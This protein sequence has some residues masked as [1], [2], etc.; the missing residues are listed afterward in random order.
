MDCWFWLSASVPHRLESP[1]LL[2][3]LS[4]AAIM[5]VHRTQSSITASLASLH[6]RCQLLRLFSGQQG[7]ATKHPTN[8]Q[9][10]VRVTSNALLVHGKQVIA[11]LAA[12]DEPYFPARFLC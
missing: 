2:S 9:D 12:Y 10:E 11:G 3:E 5:I 7:I 1:D 6:S 4:L 8:I